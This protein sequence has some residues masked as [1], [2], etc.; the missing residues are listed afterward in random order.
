M[1][2]KPY[3]YQYTIITAK[4]PY[5]QIVL[6]SELDAKETKKYRSLAG[7]LE[8]KIKRGDQAT[9]VYTY[10][11]KSRY[12]GILWAACLQRRQTAG[13]RKPM[14]AETLC[15]VIWNNDTVAVMARAHFT[16]VS[17]ENEMK[18]IEKYC[19]LVEVPTPWEM[20]PLTVTV[21]SETALG[22]EILEAGRRG[23]LFYLKSSVDPGQLKAIQ[24]S[25]VSVTEGLRKVE[26]RLGGVESDVRNTAQILE[27]LMKKLNLL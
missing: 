11:D 13:G 8:I 16:T 12:R 26:T 18:A 2:R 10:V 14:A 4:S 19:R 27:A 9:P 21:K 22:R 5:F 1:G 23:E 17:T 25:V 15:C 3:R 24:S 7:I 6:G 20:N